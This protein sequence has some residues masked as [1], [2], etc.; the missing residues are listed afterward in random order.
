MGAVLSAT[1]ISY[2]RNKIKGKELLEAITSILLSF[3]VKKVPIYKYEK[4]D[5]VKQ[6][7]GN[8]TKNRFSHRGKNGKFE[9]IKK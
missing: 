9:S 2:Y 8:R 6:N 5:R 3:K 7:K 1:I 4:V